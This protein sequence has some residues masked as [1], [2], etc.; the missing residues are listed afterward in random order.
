MGAAQCFFAYLSQ[1]QAVPDSHVQNTFISAFLFMDFFGFT[2]PTNIQHLEIP[3]EIK[4]FII[5]ICTYYLIFLTYELYFQILCNFLLS[6]Q[7]F[8]YCF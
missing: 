6:C 3:D 5:A 8:F 1:F 7:Y 2:Y 4:N